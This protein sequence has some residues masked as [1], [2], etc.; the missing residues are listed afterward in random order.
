MRGQ[1]RGVFHVPKDRMFFV[2]GTKGGVG[3]KKAVGV[4]HHHIP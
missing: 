2:P 4:E 1:I 3:H